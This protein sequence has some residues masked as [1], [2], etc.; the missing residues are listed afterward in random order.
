MET[1]R[2]HAPVSLPLSQSDSP[3]NSPPDSQPGSLPAAQAPGLPKELDAALVT[4]KRADT[5]ELIGAV[6]DSG[7]ERPQWLVQRGDRYLQLTELL[8]RV[9]E[10][11]DGSR[12]CEEIAERV[13]EAS[14]RPV[15]GDNVRTLI[16]SRLIPLDLIVVPAPPAETPA[17]FDGAAQPA[18]AARTAVPVASARRGADAPLQLTLRFGFMGPRALD[19][20]CRVLQTLFLPPIVGVVLL[21]SLVGQVWLVFVHGVGSSIQD[22]FDYPALLL[23]IYCGIILSGI[24]HEFGHA[25]ALRYGGGR[26]RGLGFGVYFMYPAFYTDCTDAYRLNRWGRMRTDLGGAY[27]DLITALALLALY[28]ATR[29]EIL[30]SAVLLL[31]LEVID[32]F[33]P[34]MRFDGYWALADLVGVP[35]FFVLIQPVVRSV[36]PKRFHKAGETAPPLKG[37]VRVVFV[38]YVAVVIPVLAGMFIGLL[39][40]APTLLGFYVSSFGEQMLDLGAAWHEGAALLVGLALLQAALLLF[41]GGLLVYGLSRLMVMIAKRLWAWGVPS[42]RRRTLAATAGALLVVLLI[43]FWIPQVV[44]LLHP[45]ATTPAPQSATPAP[46]ATK[47]PAAH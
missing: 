29:Q 7:F 24:F 4:P 16:V 47:A 41:T 40:S 20:V 15:N 26:A 46:T 10:N 17:D 28:A 32:Q 5:V 34:I 11:A 21:L 33:D 6:R 35:D 43:A 25:S 13:R 9:I 22:V 45:A 3:S 44:G 12:S 30:L 42:P 23:V 18:D 37:W 2:T 27:F 19:R 31:D 1:E 39:A 38:G 14:G 8:Y 36:L